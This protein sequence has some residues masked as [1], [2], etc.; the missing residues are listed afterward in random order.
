MDVSIIIPVQD[1]EIELLAASLEGVFAQRYGEGGIEVIVV[2][3]GAVS[4]RELPPVPAGHDVQV[5]AVNQP[6]PYAARNLAASRAT[7][8]AL[9]FTESGCVPEPDWVRAHVATLRDGAATISVGHVAPA[10]STRSVDLFLSYENVRDAWVFASPYWQHYF[11]RPKNMAVTRH[12]FETHGPFVEVMRGADSKL[13]QRIAREISCSEVGLTQGAI[14]RQQSVRGL[15]SCYRDRFRHAFALRKHRSGHAA[16]IPLEQRIRLFRET[17][18]E[19][20]YGVVSAA[21]LF[22]FLGAG[23]LTFRVGGLAAA[24]AERTNR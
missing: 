24:I 16:P 4:S 9:L 22:L 21:A 11:G 18:A 6:S 8:E 12:R 7:G 19:R 13:V 20:R 2:R 1:S 10:R 15:P 23:I 3:Y 14:V 17:L 5:L